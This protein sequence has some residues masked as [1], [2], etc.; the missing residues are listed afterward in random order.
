MR[1]VQPFE[2]QG[3]KAYLAVCVPIVRGAPRTLDEVKARFGHDARGH[4]WATEYHPISMAKLAPRRIYR[5]HDEKVSVAESIGEDCAVRETEVIAERSD[6]VLDFWSYGADGAR[7]MHGFF[8]A[9]LG[10]DA[11]KATPDSCMGCHYKL[12]ARSF[13]VRVP[14]FVALGLTLRAS[15]GIPQWVDGSMCARPGET[16]VWH[17][18]PGTS[19]PAI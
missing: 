14:S 13:D 2:H 17:V 10:V 9:R 3:I 19:D 5:S 18:R 8:P 16:I 15:Q 4:R 11:V 6:G 12:E 1:D 7:E